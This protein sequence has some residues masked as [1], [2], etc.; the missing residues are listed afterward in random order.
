MSNAA[1]HR[2]KAAEFEQLKQVDRA[3][4]M[5]IKAIDEAEAEGEEVDVALLN[6]VGDLTM[7]QGR[8]ADAVTYYERAVEHYANASLFNNAIALCN[9]I[10]RNAPGRS[11]VYFTLG[12]ICA[13]KGLRG[14][15][16]RN[17]LEYAT[18][19]QQE[20][21]IDEGMR[22]LAEVAHLMPELTEVRQ[23]VEEHATRVGIEL[24]RRMTP[25]AT[26]AS[27]AG[28]TRRDN[29]SSELIFLDIG[30]SE[31]TRNTPPLAPRIPTP[32]S[33]KATASGRSTRATP[34]GGRGLDRRPGQ[35]G[36]E[37]LDAFLLFDPTRPGAVTPVGA[38]AITPPVAPTVTSLTVAPSAP[39]ASAPDA[40]APDTS[41]PDTNAPDANAPVSVEHAAVEPRESGTAP[42][43][44][45][46]TSIDLELTSDAPT[47]ESV[48]DPI[49]EAAVASAAEPTPELMIEA[50]PELMPEVMPEAMPEAMPEVMPEAMPEAMLEAMLEVMLPEGLLE[51]DMEPDAERVLDAAAEGVEPLVVL[52]PAREPA[53]L[54]E[55][56]WASESPYGEMLEPSIDPSAAVALTG[57]V[58]G[59]EIVGVGLEMDAPILDGLLVD[60]TLIPS[61]GGV[62]AEFLEVEF[63]TDGDGDP[64]LP[65]VLDPIDSTDVE[66]LPDLLIE[67]FDHVADDPHVA[68]VTGGRTG[69]PAYGTTLP[70]SLTPIDVT[71]VP[72]LEEA[73]AAGA[74]AAERG[75]IEDV[76]EDVLEDVI[77][78]RRPPFRLDP[79]DFILPGELPPLMVDDA[80][81]Y[82][83][84][85]SA[86]WV[87][88]HSDGIPPATVDGPDH[89]DS[90]LR[91]GSEDVPYTDDADDAGDAAFEHD[92]TIFVDVRE[93]EQADSD[94]HD[95]LAGYENGA[96]TYI[97]E[98]QPEAAHHADEQVVPAH[99]T[100]DIAGITE[101]EANTDAESTDPETTGAPVVDLGAAVLEQGAPVGAEVDPDAFSDIPADRAVAT[102]P[103][104][105][106]AAVAAEANLVATSRCEE[107]GAA[108]ADAPTDW[109]LRRR[110]AE[111]LFEVGSRE[112]GLAELQVALSGFAQGGHLGVASDIADELVR[113][114]PER[115]AY[116]QKRVEL[117]VR[118]SDQVRLRGAYLDL[119]DALLAAGDEARAHAVYARVLELDPWDQRARAALGAA[120]P[121][122]PPQAAPQEEY[123][124]LAE[125]LR[126]DEPSS[127]RMR[128]R[129]PQVSGDEQADFESLLRHFKEGVS[130]SLGEEDYESHY[131]LG[132]AYKEMGLL[133]DAIAEF[134]KALR[135]RRH[136][137]PAYEALGQCFVEQSRHS[138]AATV[139]TRAL[140]EPG[141][142]DEHRVGVLYLLAYSCEALQRWDEARSYY[143]RVFATD[144][145]FRDVAARLAA[146]D[147]I[148]R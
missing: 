74:L 109:V 123:V 66:A 128:M 71:P 132:V 25:T 142:G 52:E 50:M 110:H 95:A 16:T 45:G 43:D 138:V 119:A 18:R 146:L 117:A 26:Q 127:T 121:P 131:D 143:S 30:E 49:V 72:E 59:L 55:P 144:I 23:L 140:H 41:A 104:L 5:Y 96:R 68:M 48:P 56:L 42:S 82:S 65:S 135:S 17:F 24:P 115:I 88:E 21:R 4:A 70:R 103:S 77:A 102:T 93:V 141:L 57:P 8:I 148:A 137:L 114:S 124:D 83:G 133:D 126:D 69:T 9:K 98:T 90:A 34:A 20:G 19:M 27:P 108:V 13:K 63:G 14:D 46:L 130:R 106:I 136:R 1:K 116:H 111:A 53:S 31:R 91:A 86:S 36:P 39:D 11:N 107:L 80:L 60:D 73:I 85:Q 139:L 129:A 76:I 78:E 118:L 32:P 40:S 6:K 7:R 22:A 120:A 33:S 54:E 87:P 64:G 37:S 125:W 105:P 84:L 29:R 38:R 101:T 94:G 75:A 99:P 44:T 89:N 15:A 47:G 61:E 122:P 100:D 35:A 145:H 28:P 12:R 79:H 10:L 112:R 97:D 81:V 67:D 134:Q 92:D 2:K 3:I 51:D 62:S 147:L 58:E 113:I